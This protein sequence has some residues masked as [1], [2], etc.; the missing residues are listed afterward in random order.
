MPIIC[1]TPEV[2][3]RFLHT[4]LPL[5][6]PLPL[7]SLIP[8]KVLPIELPVCHV[9]VIGRIFGNIMF[10]LTIKYCDTAE[11]LKDSFVIHHITVFL[12]YQFCVPCDCSIAVGYAK[13]L[14]TIARCSECMVVVWPK[15]LHPLL[16]SFGCGLLRQPVRWSMEEMGLRPF[17]LTKV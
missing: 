7:V 6:H 14:C 13:R 8:A 2:M 15:V 17:D 11:S 5:L 4:P 3:Q 16:Q 12:C 9:T 10:V 1:R